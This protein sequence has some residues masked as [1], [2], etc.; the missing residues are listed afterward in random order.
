MRLSLLIL[1]TV[2]LPL[3]W[4]WCVNWLVAK[5]WPS[6]QPHINSPRGSDPRQSPYDY[7]I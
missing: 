2:L 7:Q 1:L 5:W 3:V 6:R 4:G